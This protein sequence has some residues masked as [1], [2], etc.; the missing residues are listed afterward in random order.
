MRAKLRFCILLAAGFGLVPGS[1][2]AQSVP[3][4]TANTP[5]TTGVIG[6]AELRNFSLPGTVT[7]PSDQPASTGPTNASP[8]ADSSTPAPAPSERRARTA[9]ANVARPA[10]ASIQPKPQA[11]KAPASLPPS[12][13]KP[14]VTTSEPA[15]VAPP[16]ALPSAA[17]PTLPVKTD[18]SLLP[19]I[20]VGVALA[21]A[22][23]FLLFLRSKRRHGYAGPEFDLF[24]APEPELVPT[25]APPRPAP[26][27]SAPPRPVAPAP[28]QPAPSPPKPATPR[29]SGIVSTRLRPSLEMNVQPLRCHSNADE[30]L[31]EFEL[32]L[33]NVGTVP[34][35]AVLAEASMLNA[36]SAQDEQLAAFFAR[37]AAQGE[38]VDLIPPLKSMKFT[39]QVTAPRS[40][41]EEYELAGRKAFVPVIAFNAVYR[42]SG[43]QAQTSAAYLVGRE[44][45]GDKLGPLRLDGGQA[46]IRKLAARILPVGLKT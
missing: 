17:Q 35:R 11:V 7:R 10:A 44:T 9:T 32:E 13:A 36:G 14:A 1:A 19:W 28:P 21:L 34:A 12:T 25:P 38:P 8:S 26:P 33:L 15:L 37:P 42:W 29:A 41:I 40:A 18:L 46:D 4:T 6:P 24:T 27:R 16:A 23:A 5:A 30:V 3:E 43:G 2:V 22:A 39:S 31:I 20:A 45:K